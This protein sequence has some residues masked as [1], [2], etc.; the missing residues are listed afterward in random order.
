LIAVEK[1]KVGVIGAGGGIAACHIAAYL[2]NPDVELYAFCDSDEARLKAAAEKYSVSRAFTDVN[3]LL[4]LP[5]L[6]AVSVCTWNNSHAECAVAA[7]NG[8]KH[9]LCE[10][11][12]A[13]TAEQAVAMK[14]AADRNNKL[15]MFGFV[16]RFGN[17]Y[18]ILKDLIDGGFLGEIY[19][20]KAVYL[21]RDGNPGGWFG[22]KSR[23]G[24]GPLIDLGVHVIDFVRSVVGNP[25][26]VSVY[27]V[28]YQKLFDR[29]NIKCSEKYTAS[30][31]SKNDVCDVEDLAAALIRFDS[32]LTL[33]VEASFALNIK[34]DVG[35]IELFGTKGGA[36]LDPALEI[37]TETNDYLTNVSFAANT[38]LSFDGLFENEINHFVNCLTKGEKCLS[39]ARDGVDL[40]KILNAVY[41]S[42][43]TGHEVLL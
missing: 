10:K 25:K 17:D 14:E 12:P 40:M 37:Y 3:A 41:R 29:K 36:K 22:D 30:G 1:L 23:S 9:V 2:K 38:V 5:G 4:A 34:D 43:E 7:L 35:R 16:R 32:G 15:L 26:P 28:T 21:R 8:G 24:G 18:R 31:R 42:A 13:I 33:S 39:P 20:A 19:Y 6:D 27:A 11:P